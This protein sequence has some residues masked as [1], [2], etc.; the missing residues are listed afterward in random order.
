MQIALPTDDRTNVAEHFGRAAEFAVYEIGEGEARLVEHR[1]NY[2]AHAGGPHA[3]GGG[4]GHSRDFHEGLAGVDVLICRGMG[5]RATEA[6]A[7]LGVRV[8]F[9]AG[10]SLD[11]VAARFARGELEE[12]GASCGC[13]GDG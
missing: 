9:A 6:C 8:F 3:A 2:H 13:G 12:S 7:A 11:D 5:R 1:P 4:H 10:G